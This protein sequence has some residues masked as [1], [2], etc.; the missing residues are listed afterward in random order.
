MK[1]FWRELRA[2]Q[3]FKIASNKYLLSLFLFGLWMIFLDVNSL[4][5]HREL[6]QEMEELESSIA[7]Y[8]EEIKKDSTLLNQLNSE[9]E[10]FERYA[11]EQYHLKRANE[12]LYLVDLPENP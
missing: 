1:Q 10:K 9:P 7:Y 6:D 4:L 8:K 2:K 11:R 5:I 3:W 12:K